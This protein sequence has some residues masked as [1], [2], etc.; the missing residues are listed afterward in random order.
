MIKGLLFIR[1]LVETLR[2]EKIQMVSWRPLTDTQGRGNSA[3]LMG[4]QRSNDCHS[5][6]WWGWQRRLSVSPWLPQ[7][8]WRSSLKFC[9]SDFNRV[10]ITKIS[11]GNPIGGV[12]HYLDTKINSKV[13]IWISKIYMDDTKTRAVLRRQVCFHFYFQRSLLRH[14]RRFLHPIENRLLLLCGY[15]AKPLNSRVLN[16]C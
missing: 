7:S 5:L 12:F 1:S 16:Y 13:D 11:L 8:N 14:D 6:F 10:C 4:T 15:K 9:L 3:W 2:T